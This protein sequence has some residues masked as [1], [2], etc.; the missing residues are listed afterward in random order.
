M[1]ILSRGKVEFSKRES[2]TV[3]SCISPICNQVELLQVVSSFL[4]KVIGESHVEIILQFFLLLSFLRSLRFILSETLVLWKTVFRN[5]QTKYLPYSLDFNIFQDN[6]IKLCKLWKLFLYREILNM[7]IY[8]YLLSLTQYKV[9]AS[10]Q[11]GRLKMILYFIK[12][13]YITIIYYNTI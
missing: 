13:D 7:K 9:V 12:P 6:I 8:E 4:R 5:I 3:A 11:I 2:Y 10:V 1:S